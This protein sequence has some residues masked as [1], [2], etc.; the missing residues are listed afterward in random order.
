VQEAKN[1][2]NKIKSWKRRASFV[3]ERTS[4]ELSLLSIIK[5]EKAL[6]LNNLLTKIPE[7]LTRT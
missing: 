6:D 5:Q 1:Q 2:E 3:T 4:S 7:N